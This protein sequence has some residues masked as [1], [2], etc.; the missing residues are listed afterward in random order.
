MAIITSFNNVYSLRIHN[1]WKKLVKKATVST[2]HGTF[3][4]LSRIFSQGIIGEKVLSVKHI[5]F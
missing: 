1:I 5:L 2:S 3:T 4:I